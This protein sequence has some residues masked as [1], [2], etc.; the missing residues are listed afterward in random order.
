MEYPSKNN[1]SRYQ[2]LESSH[3]NHPNYICTDTN[4]KVKTLI[5]KTICFHQYPNGI[6]PPK[7]N[8]AEVQYKDFK[9]AI[10]YVFKDLKEYMKKYL[11]EVCGSTNN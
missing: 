9:S 11:I 2:H 5:A 7:Y 10:M 4:A 3:L 1:I 6:A 8:I